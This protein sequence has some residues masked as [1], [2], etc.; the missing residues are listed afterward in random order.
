MVDFFL[1]FY[2]ALNKILQDTIN[3]LFKNLKQP[4]LFVLLTFFLP[5]HS[6]PS[7]VLN[8]CMHIINLILFF[9]GFLH[10]WIDVVLYSRQRTDL[11]KEKTTVHS[12]EAMLID[13]KKK[14]KT[15]RNSRA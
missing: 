8:A 7:S 9:L 10:V 6:H 12:G 1:H 3:L 14:S 5:F 2:Y 13:S 4:F 11:K 15:M